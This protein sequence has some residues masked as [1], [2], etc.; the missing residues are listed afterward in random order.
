[1]KYLL[2]ILAVTLTANTAFAQTAAPTPEQAAAQ[3]QKAMANRPGKPDMSPQMLHA[4]KM[5]AQAMQRSKAAG[6]P[7]TAP[8]VPAR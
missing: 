7:T 6:A 4:R 3:A 1:M 5:Q 8:S 2:S